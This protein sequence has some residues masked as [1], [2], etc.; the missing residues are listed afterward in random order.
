MAPSSLACSQTAQVGLPGHWRAALLPASALLVP[1]E[2]AVLAVPDAQRVGQVR[3]HAPPQ[4]QDGHCAMGSPRGHQ[5]SAEGQG[6][7]AQ[8]GPA[9]ASGA[10][11]QGCSAGS[12]SCSGC[13]DAGCGGPA[14]AAA[15]GP[16]CKVPRHVPHAPSGP[17][18]WQLHAPHLQLQLASVLAVGCH[19]LPLALQA[20][21]AHGA[22]SLP[23]QG[24]GV[25]AALPHAGSVAAGVRQPPPGRQQG[26]LQH[27]QRH[28]LQ[29]EGRGGHHSCLCAR[30]PLTPPHWP[31]TKQGT[32]HAGRL[33]AAGLHSCQGGHWRWHQADA[34]QAQLQLTTGSATHRGRQSQRGHPCCQRVHGSQQ[35]QVVLREHVSDRNTQHTVWKRMFEFPN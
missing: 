25:I 17:P 3:K 2:D 22:G 26:G 6:G 16:A 10:A 29:G 24:A 33:H 23:R 28:A 12:C 20:K 31:H 8:E 9:A 19:L 21:H 30:G 34:M 13:A 27:A 5:L 11:G 7:C 1:Q 15:A 18:L 32:T 35:V 4:G 14:P